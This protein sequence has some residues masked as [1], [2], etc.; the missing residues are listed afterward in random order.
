MFLP[1]TTVLRQGLIQ[2]SAERLIARSQVCAIVAIL[3]RTIKLL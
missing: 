2:S 3:A 1:D